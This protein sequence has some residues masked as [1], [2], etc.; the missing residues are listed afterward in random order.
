MA[1]PITSADI[2]KELNIKRSTF[3]YLLKNNLI[4]IS[5]TDTGRYAW[6]NEVVEQLKIVLSEPQAIEK[7]MPEIKTTRIN[8]RR[9]LGNKYK[10]LDFITSTV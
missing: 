8:N 3:Y 10:L 1:Q 4:S 6:N 9:Y 2:L 7:E 5:T